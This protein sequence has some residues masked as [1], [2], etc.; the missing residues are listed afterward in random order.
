MDPPSRT[1]GD[2]FGG[3]GRPRFVPV[4]TYRLQIHAGFP[5]ERGARDR[6]LPAAPRHRRR[7]HVAVLRR[8]AR[9]HARLRRHQPQRDQS[10]GRAARRRTRRFTDAVREAGLQHIVDFVPNHMGISTATNPWWR[11]V[12]A[13]GPESPSRALLRHRL[14]PVQDGAAAQAAAADP[15]R[16][17]RRGPRSRRAAARAAR[18]SAGAGVFRQPAA[19]QRHADLPSCSG[20][21][22]LSPAAARRCSRSSTACPATRAVVRPR[23]T[24]CSKTQAY[25][26]AYWRTAS[27]EIN[28]RRFFDVN[29][30]AGL[31]VEDPDVFASIHRLLAR[32][33]RDGARHRR[34]DRSSG[35]AVRSG[36]LLRHAAGPRGRA[37]D[38]SGGHGARVL[39]VVAEKILS[40]RERLPSGWAVHGT[41]G[42]QLPQPGERAVRGPGQRAAHAPR[43]RQADRPD[44][45]LRRPALRDQAADHGHRDGQRAH[46]ARAHARSHRREQPAS[47]ATSR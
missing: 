36:A 18:R 2:R 5:L 29:T 9:Q 27:H 7:L 47:R 34:A 16:P 13:N 26:L 41:T 32:L 39:Y 21:P 42:L 37:W 20:L 38:S 10:R 1:S 14:E 8:R 3:T 43:L 44:A 46:G 19:D 35:R 28:Y 45:E 30:L 12:L 24:S 22:E 17:V 31:R 15:R 11:D 23:C 40:G 4:S 33:L 25:R 6:P